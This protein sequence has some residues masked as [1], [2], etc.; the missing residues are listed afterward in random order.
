MRY[1]MYE[2]TVEFTKDG[3]LEPWLTLWADD[4]ADAFIAAD[5]LYKSYQELAYVTITDTRIG[6]VVKRYERK[7]EE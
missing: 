6:K 5:R 7:D 3:E 2:I 4:E 1:E